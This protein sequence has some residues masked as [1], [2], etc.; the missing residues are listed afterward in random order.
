MELI[1][2]HTEFSRLDEVLRD[3]RSGQSQVLVLRGPVSNPK[4][5]SHMR[6]YNSCARR[7]WTASTIFRSRSVMP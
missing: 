1:D 7:C 2:R 3:V 6:H 5:S 4:G